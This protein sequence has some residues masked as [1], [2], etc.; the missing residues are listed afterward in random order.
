MK[1]TDP[2]TPPDQTDWNVLNHAI[3]Y[4][5]KGQHALPAEQKVPTQAEVPRRPRPRRRTPRIRTR[6]A[7]RSGRRR[8]VIRR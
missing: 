2:N 5:T 6:R 8:Q 4:G 3:W 1:F 7:G